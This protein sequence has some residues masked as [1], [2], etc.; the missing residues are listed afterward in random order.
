MQAGWST[1]A[2]GLYVHTEQAD[3]QSSQTGHAVAGEGYLVEI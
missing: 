2:C 1:L 3:M